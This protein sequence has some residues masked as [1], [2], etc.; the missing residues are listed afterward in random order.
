MGSR[1]QR[2]IHH[3]V[4]QE[5][6]VGI[7][8]ETKFNFN[9]Q[10]CTTREQSERLLALG[11]KKETADCYYWQ[12]TE[13]MYGEAAGIWHL[14]TLDSKDNQEHFEYLDKNF[15]VCLADD[16]EH[17][18]IPAWSLGRLIEI[19]VM[20]TSSQIL[21]PLDNTFDGLI[22]DIETRIKGGYFNKEYLEEELCQ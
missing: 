3:R 1:R 16:E 9:S 11:L 18:F 8:M 14:E 17:Y 5:D 20:K 2:G 19:K 13:P 15:G 4:G 22:E 7:V 21:L 12:E 10:I 6:N